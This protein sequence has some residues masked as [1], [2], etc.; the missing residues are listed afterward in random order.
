[1]TVMK[2]LIV[3]DEPVARRVLREE[4]EQIDNI[5]VAGEAQDGVTHSLRFSNCARISCFSICRCQVWAVSM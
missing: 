3:D 5:V 2:A 1:M 4:L